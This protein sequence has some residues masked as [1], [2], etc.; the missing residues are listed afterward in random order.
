MFNIAICEIQCVQKHIQ[1][2]RSTWMGLQKELLIIDFISRRNNCTFK[3]FTTFSMMS[4]FSVHL[5][6][7]PKWV[8]EDGLLTPESIWPSGSSQ[9]VVVVEQGKDILETIF[10]LFFKCWCSSFGGSL[11]GRF[12]QNIYWCL[13]QLAIWLGWFP[14]NHPMLEPTWLKIGI[15][16]EKVQANIVKT[17]WMVLPQNTTLADCGIPHIP[18]ITS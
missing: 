7:P 16:R 12:E 8:V 14:P 15:K 11:P 10:Y 18:H 6:R 13:G 2:F 3:T 9:K 1:N 4:T 5:R 17:D